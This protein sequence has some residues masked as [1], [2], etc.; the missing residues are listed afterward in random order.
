M[1][2]FV[3]IPF[4]FR[5]HLLTRLLAA[6]LLNTHCLAPGISVT[7]FSYFTVTSRLG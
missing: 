1:N 4:V 2:A 7:V 3:T 5:R 6:I